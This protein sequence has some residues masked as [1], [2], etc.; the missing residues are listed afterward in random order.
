MGSARSP[1]VV[2]VHGAF[3]GGWCW[4]ALQAELDR[5][6]IPSLAPDLP[7]HGASLEPLGNL[8]DDARS[9]RALLDRLRDHGRD[10]V[11][12]A[13]SYGGAVATQAAAGAANVGHIVYVTAFVPDE[14]ET[15]LG[16]VGSLPAAEYALQAAM[17]LG[18]TSCTIDPGHARA[19]FYGECTE[20]VAGAAAARLDTQALAT[21]SEPLTA[22]A[23]R[24]IPSTYVRCL[25]DQAL[26]DVHQV[27]MAARCNDVTTLDTDHSPFASKT[28]ELADVIE[29]IAVAC[30]TVA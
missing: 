16:L 23:W 10:V 29:R 1:L 18:E 11:L 30:R 9:V 7:G 12:V 24:S 8:S 28:A 4:S 19:T 5:R 26:P 14:G 17:V 27:V 6:A 3:H 25:R 2:L 21:F 22:A 20:R 15:V 13:H